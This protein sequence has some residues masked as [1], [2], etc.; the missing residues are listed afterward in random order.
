MADAFDTAF[1]DRFVSVVDRA[2]PLLT[3]EASGRFGRGVVLL[4][5]VLVRFGLSLARRRENRPV[6][7]SGCHPSFVR[8]GAKRAK[9]QGVHRRYG[10][11]AHRKDISEDTADTGRG[12]L[13]RF[14]KTRVVM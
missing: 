9:P 10:P 2:G 1:Q 14:D 6:I 5:A 4:N 11:G 12:P 3:K 7:R 13:E 8:R